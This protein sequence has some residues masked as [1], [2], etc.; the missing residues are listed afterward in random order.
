[1]TFSIVGT[2]AGRRRA[3]WRRR[4]LEVPRRRAAVPAAEADV[5]AVAT[6]AYA[7]L[8]YR[9]DGLALLRAGRAAQE[10]R[11][12]ALVTADDGREQRQAGVVDAHGG[13][14]T[15]TG[16]G[17]HAWAG[18]AHRRRLRRPGQHPHRARGGRGDG[19]AR[20]SAAS[21]RSRSPQRLLAALARGDHA[22]GDRRGRQSAALLVVTPGGGYGGES[23]RRSSTCASTTTPTP[24]PELRPAARPARPLLRQARPGDAAAARGRPRRRGR[25][26]RGCGHRATSTSLERLGRRRELRGADGRTARIDPLVLDKLRAA[27]DGPT[28]MSVLAI[29]AGTTGVTALVVGDGRA[30]AA[31]GYEEFPQHFP[32]PGWVE[33]EPEE[34][35]QA[36]LSAC[37]QALDG[38]RRPRRPPSASPTSARPRCSGTARR[39]PHRAARSSGRTGGTA[40]ICDRLR[41]AGHEDRGRAS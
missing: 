36:T 19:G 5:G 24:V 17:C 12:D 33:H 41:D 4:G 11:C 22:G 2:L 7:N 14:A 23:R 28:P 27:S 25:D 31:R 30:V 37:R 34:I 40:A 10:T 1:M 8:A 3:V 29:D 35:W 39:S 15:Y 21:R 6:Q 32:R 38:R 16:D 26:A 13:A 18:G 20:G 9:P